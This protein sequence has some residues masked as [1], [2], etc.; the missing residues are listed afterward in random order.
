MGL[1]N[2]NER[3]GKFFLALGTLCGICVGLFRMC[4][5]SVG[6][7]KEKVTTVQEASAAENPE[8]ED[9]SQK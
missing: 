1:S 3:I 2:L 9:N 5:A 6:M 7:I 8:A 4:K